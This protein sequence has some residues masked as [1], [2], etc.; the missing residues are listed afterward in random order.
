MRGI[1]LAIIIGASAV[2][3]AIRGEPLSSTDLRLYGFA[4]LGT[5]I[6][7]ASGW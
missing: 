6:V 2:A 1:A 4:L 5:L 3:H 7:I